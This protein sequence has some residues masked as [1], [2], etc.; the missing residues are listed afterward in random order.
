[1][2]MQTWRANR[3]SRGKPSQTPGITKGDSCRAD[4]RKRYFATRSRSYKDPKYGEWCQAMDAL[5]GNRQR[6]G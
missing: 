1:M 2:T 3:L 4:F 5:N 6:A